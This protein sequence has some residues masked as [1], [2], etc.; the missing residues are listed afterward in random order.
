LQRCPCFAFA[1]VA[2]H[3]HH[4]QRKNTCALLPTPVITTL[5]MGVVGMFARVWVQ[6]LG[7]M[8]SQG[9]R[10]CITR[11]LLLHVAQ[12]HHVQSCS[13]GVHL[14]AL[15]IGLWCAC[16][17]RYCCGAVSVILGGCWCN[18]PRGTHTTVAACNSVWDVVFSSR[19]LY[20]L[21]GWCFTH[22]CATPRH[23]RVCY[24]G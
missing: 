11:V 8:M 6:G 24:Q 5:T 13:S 7:R 15:G 9:C 16:C 19:M 20:L 22:C 12:G 23:G 3:T 21:Q 17:E 10:C 18:P 2:L 4:L 1:A 14:T